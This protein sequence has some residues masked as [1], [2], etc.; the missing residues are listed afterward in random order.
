MGNFWYLL[1]PTGHWKRTSWSVLGDRLRP[2]GGSCCGGLPRREAWAAAPSQACLPHPGVRAPGP[3]SPHPTE[4]PRGCGQGCRSAEDPGVGPPVST[5]AGA[6]EPVGSPTGERK[7]G[8]VAWGAWQQRCGQLWPGV[9]GVYRRHCLCGCRWGL[10][11]AL[12]L[13]SSCT[14][15]SRTAG[16]APLQTPCDVGEHLF[17][18]GHCAPCQAK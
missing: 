1:S 8:V 14:G 7:S 4:C 2:A 17:H 11:S 5:H 3:C 6:R 15:P 18:S 13:L 10:P 9:G 16:P 12:S